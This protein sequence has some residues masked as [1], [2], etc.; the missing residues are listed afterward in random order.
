[1]RN[2]VTV[3]MVATFVADVTVVTVVAHVT[4]VTVVTV[5]SCDRV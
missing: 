5:V 4:A 2:C 1:M 3:K